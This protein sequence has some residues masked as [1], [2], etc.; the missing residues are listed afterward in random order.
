VFIVSVESPPSDQTR[1][2]SLQ[3]FRMEYELNWNYGYYNSTRVPLMIVEYVKT[4]VFAC[5]GQRQH[6]D[7]LRMA[8]ISALGLLRA[9]RISDRVGI[10]GLLIDRHRGH[11]Y[12]AWRDEMCQKVNYYFY[13]LGNCTKLN[14]RIQGS[15]HCSKEL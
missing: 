13:Q 2:R 11:L 14:L 10:F 5:D 8:M 12:F 1:S 9:H 15:V 7:H 6:P 3:Q 4:N